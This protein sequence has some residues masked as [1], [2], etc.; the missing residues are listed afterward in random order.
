[1]EPRQQQLHVCSQQ[2]RFWHPVQQRHPRGCARQTL[3]I[4]E[5]DCP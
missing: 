4:L 2:L 3:Q 1:V 5:R